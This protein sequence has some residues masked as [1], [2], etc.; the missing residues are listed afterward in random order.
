MSRRCSGS[1]LGDLVCSPDLLEAVPPHDAKDTRPLE[2]LGLFTS[3]LPQHVVQAQ[4]ASI[5]I[6]PRPLQTVVD[7]V[8]RG[9][10]RLFP[11]GSGPD[12]TI[13]IAL[14]IATAELLLLLLPVLSNF[15]Y[16]YVCW[17]C[18]Y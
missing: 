14:A 9:A 3:C 7:V 5:S 4:V 1:P 2:H 11:G 18:Y 13:A 12:M 17:Y 16:Y 8:K 10:S 15:Y 6:Q